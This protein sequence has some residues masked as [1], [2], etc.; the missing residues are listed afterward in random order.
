ML[1]LGETRFAALTRIGT[2]PAST[3][4]F[5]S[6]IDIHPAIAVITRAAFHMRPFIFELSELF[7]LV[8]ILLQ[9]PL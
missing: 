3:E 9:F 8:S 5:I 1:P 2:P 4:L 6:G 7:I